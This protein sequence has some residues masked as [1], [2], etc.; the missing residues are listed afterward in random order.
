MRQN[1]CACRLFMRVYQKL[2][3]ACH[4]F[5]T[6]ECLVESFVDQFESFFFSNLFQPTYSDTSVDA[7]SRVSASSK[8]SK[9]LHSR[10]SVIMQM[11]SPMMSMSP[12]RGGGGGGRGRFESAMDMSLSSAETPMTCGQEAH[13]VSY[14]LCVW[15]IAVELSR[16]KSL[17]NCL[18]P[19]I[20]FPKS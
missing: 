5:E 3:Q 13:H 10:M 11:S 2:P 17:M 19:M 9:P 12:P 7:M 1:K 8:M 16:K 20:K 6:G 18:N 4:H 15:N 14:S